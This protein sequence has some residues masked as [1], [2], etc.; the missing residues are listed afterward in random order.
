MD[1]DDRPPKIDLRLLYAS[2]AFLASECWPT[3]A[4]DNAIVG[5]SVLVAFDGQPPEKPLKIDELPSGRV[6]RGRQSSVRLAVFGRNVQ[7]IA[8]A[9]VL[10]DGRMITW[11]RDVEPE[12]ARFR[13]ETEHAHTLRALIEAKG[14]ATSAAAQCCLE[15]VREHEARTGI[16]R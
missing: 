14:F 3:Y 1:H 10:P 5:G 12:D 11:D 9:V 8:T 2:E 16:E 15:Q 13:A 6:V 7:I 4:Q